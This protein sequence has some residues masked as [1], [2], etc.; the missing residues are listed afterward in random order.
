MLAHRY[1]GNVRH[2]VTAAMIEEDL[3][4]RDVEVVSLVENDVRKHSR[5]KSFKLSVKRCDSGKID[6]E[7]FWPSNVVVRRWHNPR[8]S[9]AP[10][11]QDG[12]DGASALS[13]ES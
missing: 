5:Y 13:T 4:R 3:K 1:I 7:D 12:N 11:G 2:D 8:Q 9:K 6:V 10:A